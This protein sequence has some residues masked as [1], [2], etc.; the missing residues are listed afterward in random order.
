MCIFRSKEQPELTESQK[1]WNRLWDN[2]SAGKLAETYPLVFLICDYYSGVSGEGHS[3]WFF[4]TENTYGQDALQTT[5]S[6]LKEILPADMSENLSHAY[7]SLGSEN[8]DNI[9]KKADEFFYEH[10]QKVTVVLQNYADN[11]SL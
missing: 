10:E 9:C 2:Y 6:A 1:K 8:E 4:N 7:D 3:G 11:L 5:I